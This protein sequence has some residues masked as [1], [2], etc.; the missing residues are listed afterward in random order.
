MP[1]IHHADPTGEVDELTAIRVESGD[2][3]GA[4]KGSVKI[5]GDLM[6]TGVRWDAES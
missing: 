1:R 4:L 6:S 3:L 5:R 2:L